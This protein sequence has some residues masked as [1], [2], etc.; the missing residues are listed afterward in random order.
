MSDVHSS[1]A[2]ER[3]EPRRTS[4]RNFLRLAGLSGAALVIPSFLTACTSED[5]ID[6]ARTADIDLSTDEGLL[7]FSWAGAQVSYEMYQTSRFYSPYAGVTALEAATIQV[8]ANH[9]S[10][11]KLLYFRIG[12]EAIPESFRF[13]WDGLDY[14]SRSSFYPFI[15]DYEELLAGGYAWAIA[16]AQDPQVATLIAKMGSVAGRHVAV[17]QDLADVYA[18]GAATAARTSFANADAIEAATGLQRLINPTEFLDF[19]RPYLTTPLS[20]R[21][22]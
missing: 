6:P 9:G 14:S 5:P 15:K 11:Y 16:N 3:G 7:A 17:V 21:G 2:H 1:P 12:D 19:I 18:G 13:R 20:V 10:A 8:L 22:A 4:R